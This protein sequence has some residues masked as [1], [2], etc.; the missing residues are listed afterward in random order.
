M[1]VISEIIQAVIAVL[2]LAPT[3]IIVVHQVYNR[4]P[5]MVPDILATLDGAIIAFYF[6]GVITTQVSKA[7]NGA[8]T[9]NKS[10]GA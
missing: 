3:A 4:Q 5:V 8:L 9:A 2:V 10:P 7:V 1:L 6:R